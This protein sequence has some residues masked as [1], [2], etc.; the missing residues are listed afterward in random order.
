[1]TQKK[2]HSGAPGPSRTGLDAPYHAN[3]EFCNAQPAIDPETSQG[4]F[5][6]VR[7]EEDAVASSI[8]SIDFTAAFSASLKNFTMGAF[9]SHSRP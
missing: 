5:P 1:V 9:H 2:V 4:D 3:S 8:L 7:A 6:F